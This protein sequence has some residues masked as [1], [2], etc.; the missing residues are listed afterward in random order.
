MKIKFIILGLA[1]ILCLV[2]ILSGCFPQTHAKDK[3]PENVQPADNQSQQTGQDACLPVQAELNI[4]KEV[5][6]KN[7]TMQLTVINNAD[8]NISLGR[9][10]TI[11]EYKDGKWSLCPLELMFTMELITLKPGEVFDQTVEL[12]DLKPGKYRI[13][14]EINFEESE[15]SMTLSRE[16]EIK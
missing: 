2:F 14:K 6:S 3:Q 8:S 15:T 7:E 5:Y 1:C 4:N 13:S 9:P 10:Y 12:N 11:E 16:F